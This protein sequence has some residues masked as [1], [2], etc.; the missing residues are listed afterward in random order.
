MRKIVTS[1]VSPPI[2]TRCC[3]WCAHYDGEEEDGNY[4]W[5]ATEDEAVRD[6]LDN[7]AED[8]DEMPPLAKAEG[9]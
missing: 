4:G 2:P 9:R 5:G 8:M 3:D 7:Y 1:Y 6:F